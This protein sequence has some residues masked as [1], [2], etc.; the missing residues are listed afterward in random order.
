MF[1]KPLIFG[2]AGTS[3]T[4]QEKELLSKNPIYG[5]ILFKRNIV[6]REQLLKLVQDLRG[7][8]DYNILIFVDQEGGRVA[9]LKP[10]IID[11][12]Y[13]PAGDFGRIYD[14]E[15]AENAYLKVFA[16]YSSLMKSLKEYRIDSPCC[17]VA[18]LRYPYTDN[19]IG[20]RSFGD[21]VVKVV[22]LCAKTIEAI[23]GQGGI[24]II[25]HILGHG[26]ATCDSHYKLPSVTS[27]LAELNNT[28]FEVFRQLSK[29]AKAGW[30]MTAHIIFE[31]L[32]TN[33]PVTLSPTAIKFIRNDIGFKG[34]L[35]SDDICML[36]LHGEIGAKYSIV[37]KPLTIFEKQDSTTTIS[38]QDLEKLIE[39]GIIK[40]KSDQTG[41]KKYLV[42]EFPKLKAEF[43]TS[44]VEVARQTIVAGCDLVLH[45]S[46]DIQ[47]MTAVCRVV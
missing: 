8:Y 41:L 1:K 30:A 12:E 25:K 22:G 27:S 32:D 23:E 47:E 11:I 45:C 35:V 37:K 20:D 36:A 38:N 13:P 42:E 33:L 29:N 15:G 16:N 14:Q 17:P 39:Y 2:I 34:M 40:D 24:A 43:V 28:D 31:A 26:R 9:R 19:A 10:P 5:F 4:M 3:L 21:S 44:I 7:L 46:G 18:D 6:D